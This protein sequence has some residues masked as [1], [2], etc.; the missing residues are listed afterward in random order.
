MQH[1]IGLMDSGVGGTGVL[2]LACRR[3]RGYHF[4][5]LGDQAATPYGEKTEQEITAHAHACVQTLVDRGCETVV[6]ACN[7]ATACAVDALRAR[8]AIPIIGMEPAI[9]PARQLAGNLPVLV[10]ATPA[11]FRLPRYKRLT[12]QVGGQFVSVPCPE[13][14]RMVEHGEN[15]QAIQAHL[16]RHVPQVL[17]ENL[18]QAHTASQ[19]PQAKQARLA[20][21]ATQAEQAYLTS[22]ALQAVPSE[23]AYGSCD[24]EQ[25]NLDP[26]DMGAIVLGCTHFIYAKPAMAA[27]WPGVPLVDGHEGAVNQLARVL[28]ERG[29]AGQGENY[30]TFE[31]TGTPR[32]LAALKRMFADMEVM[33]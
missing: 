14:V 29:L 1:K 11:T 13:L 20:N 28:T 18:E 6:L 16:A 24:M 31:S 25:P 7:T 19:A 21:D 15:A 32:E 30:I 33:V 22:Q 12:E 5:Y 26:A 23:T 4:I 8:F 10:L 17:R 2:A 9:K 27:L 3:L